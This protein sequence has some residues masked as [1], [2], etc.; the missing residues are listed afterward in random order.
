[1]IVRGTL[2]P[3]LR[4][5]KELSHWCEDA[6]NPWIRV[7]ACPAPSPSAYLIR[8][9]EYFGEGMGGRG[10]GRQ[11]RSHDTDAPHPIEPLRSLFQ[12][13]AKGRGKTYAG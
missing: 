4:S 2:W 12:G 9:E 8:A 13:L 3:S 6:P 5:L 1:M 11:G 7:T 10:G